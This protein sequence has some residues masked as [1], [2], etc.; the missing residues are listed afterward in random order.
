LLLGVPRRR[1]LI[2]AGVGVGLLLT[3]L[4]VFLFNRGDGTPKPS[5]EL[6][7]VTEPTQPRPLRLAVTPPEFDDVG[8]LL[9]ELGSGFRYTT[10]EFD[11]LLDVGRLADYDVVFLTCSTLPRDW[12][13]E[14]LHE[15]DRG[16]KRGAVRPQHAKW[17][18]ENL[19]AYVE[20]GGTLYASDWQFALMQI[21]FPEFIDHERVASGAAGTIEAEVVDA[22][23]RKRLG[24]TIELRF[25]KEAWRPAALITGGVS[26]AAAYL[27]GTYQTADGRDVHGPLLVQFSFGKGHVVFTSFHNEKQNSRTERELLRYLVFATVTARIDARATRQML[28]GGFSPV[29]RNLLSA[30]SQDQSLTGKYE[31]AAVS[32]LQFVLACEK[33][34]AKLHLVVVGPHGESRQESGDE[35]IT[36]DVP[37]A[38]AGTWKYTITPIELPDENFPFTITVGQK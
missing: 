23:L 1:L 36:V 37:A 15:G 14:A 3:L 7:D 17:I 31:N 34:G 8:K 16:G 29:D 20:G 28:A 27:R 19:R 13:G 11:D 12:V 9:R 30:S 32:D 18:R 21:A 38:A 25:D 24:P 33:R 35:T 10:I 2:D 26:P 6:L 4:I 22:G 5:G